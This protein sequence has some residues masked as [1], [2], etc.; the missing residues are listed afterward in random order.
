MIK[1]K[2]AS[3]FFKKFS[4]QI[5][6]PDVSEILGIQINNIDMSQF[7]DAAVRKERVIS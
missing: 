4:Y 6:Q 3:H 1:S 7:R 5:E 2:S